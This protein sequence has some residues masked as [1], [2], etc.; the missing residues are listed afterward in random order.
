MAKCGEAFSA[1]LK[2]AALRLNLETLR[3]SN[4]FF[5]RRNNLCSCSCLLEG[6]ARLRKLGSFAAI[7]EHNLRLVRLSDCPWDPYFYAASP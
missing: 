2:A 5:L 3:A 7:I 4:F 6:L 1:A